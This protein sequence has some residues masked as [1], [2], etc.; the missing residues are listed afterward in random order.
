M[1]TRARNLPE[2]GNPP[3]PPP[4]PEIAALQARVAAAEVE[5]AAAQAA[6]AAADANPATPLAIWFPIWDRLVAADAELY[7]AR[8]ALEI[9]QTWQGVT[10]R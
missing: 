2:G 10:A 7:R 1:T 3:P 8:T 9:V 6:Q 4:P 5:H